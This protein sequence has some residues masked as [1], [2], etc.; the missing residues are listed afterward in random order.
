MTAI[1]TKFTEKYGLETPIAQAGMAFAGMTP[2]LG[3]AVSNAGAMGSI[4][5]VGILPP[6]AVR[7]LVAGTQAGTASF[8]PMGPCAHG[9]WYQVPSIK[10][11]VPSTKY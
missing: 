11:Q 6:E 5:G 4:A 3:I 2:D 8:G 7:M 9:P 1:K 10:Y